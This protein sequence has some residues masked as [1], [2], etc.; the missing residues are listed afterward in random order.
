MHVLYALK[1]LNSGHR[2]RKV[3]AIERFEIEGFDHNWRILFLE[4][5]S[6]IERCPLWRGYTEL[7]L[8]KIM[9]LF[10]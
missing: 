6:A 10:I 5:V 3:S 8:E 7:L 1:P 2:Y 4:K 9:N